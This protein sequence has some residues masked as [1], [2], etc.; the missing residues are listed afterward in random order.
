MSNVSI[1]HA[2]AIDANTTIEVKQSRPLS[3]SGE[4]PWCLG[5]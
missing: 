3:C 1:E 5:K 2:L 4:R